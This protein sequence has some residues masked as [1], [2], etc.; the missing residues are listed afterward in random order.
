MIG[1]TMSAARYDTHSRSFAA[2]HEYAEDA[3]KQGFGCWLA[4]LSIAFVS[5]VAAQ[6]VAGQQA[7][8]TYRVGILC[9]G[10]AGADRA[11]STF[12]V[13]ERGHR[14]KQGRPVERRRV[15]SVVR[16]SPVADR[17]EAAAEVSF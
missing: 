8:K 4:A 12:G 5:L 13:G 7:E 9:G 6:A 1:R 15:S 3:M 11:A 2:I 14:L 17:A 10:G 16:L